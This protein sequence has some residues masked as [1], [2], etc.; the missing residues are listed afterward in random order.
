MIGGHSNEDEMTRSTEVELTKTFSV[1]DFEFGPGRR[2]GLCENKDNPFVTFSCQ[3]EWYIN[4]T[5]KKYHKT[6]MILW[7][8]NIRKG[9]KNWIKD[10]MLNLIR[11]KE[12]PWENGIKNT[13][14]VRE[15]DSE[16]SNDDADTD[17]KYDA[18]FW[19]SHTIWNFGIV[20]LW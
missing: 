18:C 8:A 19:I 1:N 20:L 17:K 2:Y 9:I 14:R 6:C 7:N 5:S 16:D 15:E 13:K 10:V 3:L 4:L 12:F 11:R